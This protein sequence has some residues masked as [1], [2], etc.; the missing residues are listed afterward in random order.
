MVKLQSFYI[1][2]F[3]SNR[4]RDCNYEI[5]NITLNEARKNNEVIRLSDSELLRKIRKIRNNNFDQQELDNLLQKKKKKEPNS[6]IGEHIDRLLYIND[7]IIIEFNDSRHYKSIINKGGIW[8]NGKRYVRLLAGAGMT[9]RSTVMFIMDEIENEVR[10]FL[11]CGRDLNYKIA[12]SKYNAYVALAT[13]STQRVSYPNFIV[14]PDCEIERIINVDFLN[15]SNDKTK[16]LI[17]S[18]RQVKIKTNLFDGQGIVSPQLTRKWA[19]ELII[20]YLPSEWIVRAPYL[21]GLMVT[22]D[23]HKFARENGIEKITDIYGETHWI[24]RIDVI[25][26]ESQFKLWGA[27]TNTESYRKECEKYDF[28]WGITKYAPRIDKD[29]CFGTYQYLQNLNIATQKQIENLCSKTVEWFSK[30]TGDWIYS[31][32]FLLGDVDANE[33]D[34]DWFES[35]DNDLLQILLLEPQFINDKNVQQKILRLIN[36]KIRESYLGVLLLDGNY[37]FMIADPVA[38]IEYALG[39][40][41]KGLLKEGEHYSSY[42][43]NKEI[44]EVAALRSP[45]TWRSEVN[46]LNLQNNETI[47]KWYEYLYSGIV[48]NVFGNDCLKMSGAD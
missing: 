2:K 30:V 4:L 40:P 15:E 29:Y 26:S 36:K 17:I 8:I 28:A 1:L 14:I 5:K 48:F 47:Q 3:N 10:Q 27:Y 18:P 37:Q 39:L 11:N 7:I 33:I 12:P 13:S 32:L 34:S 38:Q 42:W 19:Q 21:K 24:E 45:M 23:F 6:S 35:L 20:D 44:T 9:R 46:V 41:I 43:N 22:F 31:L 25:V 16:D